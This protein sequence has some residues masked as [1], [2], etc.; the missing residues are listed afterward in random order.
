MKSVNLNKAPCLFKNTV[1]ATRKTKLG[2]C[3]W[4]V[5]SRKEFN[6][7]SHKQKVAFNRICGVIY[8]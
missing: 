7:L 3:E 2:F 4:S 6:N 5:L 8:K 1:T